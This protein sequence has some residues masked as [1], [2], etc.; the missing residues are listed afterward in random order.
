M[1]VSDGVLPLG[2]GA[3]DDELS[4]GSGVTDELSL[5]SGVADDVVSLG[6]GVG[7]AVTEALGSTVSSARTEAC[8]LPA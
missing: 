5:G 2:S 4:L 7:V 3:V 8:A 1:G 6:S